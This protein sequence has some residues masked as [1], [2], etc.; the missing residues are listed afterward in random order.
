[1]K[2][3]NRKIAILTDTGSSITPKEA[4]DLDIYLL[5]LQIIN[6]DKTYSDLVDLD[7]KQIY[8]MI[9]NEIPLTTSLPA[10]SIIYDTIEQ[11]KKDG[12]ENIIAVPLT[13]GLSSTATTIEAVAR[14]LK[15]PLTVVNTYS[16]CQIQRHVV[17]RIK[18]LLDSQLP[19]DDVISIVQYEI[20]NSGSY[21]LAS[22]LNHLKRGGRLTPLAASFANMLK[23]Y[24]ILQLNKSTEGKIDVYTKVRTRKKALIQLVDSSIPITNKESYMFY[25]INSDDLESSHFIKEQL[26]SR[27]IKE[28]MIK[29]ENINSVVSVHV[30]MKC[31][32]LQTIR[33]NKV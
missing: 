7:T 9:Y 28:D 14:E 33:V 23:I 31:L 12:Y 15:I 25:I 11:I 10:L 29:I 21:I 27:G 2:E 17:L 22:D 16:T 30:G 8:D 18:K 19:L 13:N 26:L 3:N 32:A 5:P 6:G 4:I 20:D 1:M 24:P